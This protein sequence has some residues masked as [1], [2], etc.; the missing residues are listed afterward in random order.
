MDSAHT[1]LTQTG[2]WRPV[3]A[4]VLVGL[5]LTAC[6]RKHTAANPAETLHKTTSGEI[7][8]ANLDADIAHWTG[9]LQQDGQATTG[10]YARLQSNLVLRAALRLRKDDYLAAQAIADRAIA[11]YP[12][13]P[14]AWLLQANALSAVHRY[15]A[16]GEMIDKAT[17]FADNA[18]APMTVAIASRRCHLARA[19]G[20]YDTA[21]RCAGDTVT[22]APSAS[23]HGEYAGLLA[24]LGRHEAALA[25]FA[26]AW[27][28]YK[29]P[30][31]LIPAWLALAQSKALQDAGQDEAAAKLLVEMQR[32][33][34]QHLRLTVETA[35]AL[36][37][38]GKRKAAV[39]M[40]EPLLAQTDDPDV[41]N[42]LAGWL[43]DAGDAEAAKAMAARAARGFESHMHVLPAAYAAHAAEF[44]AGV[45]N[46]TAKAY[47]L[48][49]GNARNSPS[50][51]AL[52]QLLE[53]GA[54]AGQAD[55]ACQL[56]Q[57]LV[58][59]TVLREARPDLLDCK[60]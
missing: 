21:L 32:R 16:A 15:E 14:A 8:V 27:D 23:S 26:K 31:P 12:E 48:A 55:Q 44:Y 9:Q 34:P 54:A 40:L 51:P 4:L 10:R 7:V 30:S 50:V 52:E 6:E 37:A 2:A 57:S 49:M 38:T 22:A 36:E 35:V 58:T 59:S 11:D 3:A 45:G 25:Q 46:D 24:E 60:S 47:S 17:E 29:K 13:Q 53:I 28:S 42:L 18:D 1:F 39:A 41:P 19:A 56:V 33:F 5:A 43:A 20:D